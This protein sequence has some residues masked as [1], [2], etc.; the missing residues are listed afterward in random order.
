MSDQVSELYWFGPSYVYHMSEKDYLKAFHYDSATRTVAT[1]PALV[2]SVRPLDGMPGGFS[3]LSANGNTNGIVWTLF[4]NGDGQWNKVTGSFVAFDATSLAELWRDANPVSFAKFCAPTIADGKVFRPTFA[5]E[6]RFGVSGKVI[7][8]GLRP[9]GMGMRRDD[10]AA[11]AG[12][13]LT[14]DRPPAKSARLAMRPEAYIA[15]TGRSFMARVATESRSSRPPTPNN[16]PA[17]TRRPMP[18]RSLSPRSIGRRRRG[19]TWFAARSGS[20]GC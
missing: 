1:T 5:S 20:T 18:E 3:S 15:T 7:V 2:A 10:S 13:R 17:T 9:A 14:T 16:R 19:R 12:G 11:G 4:P 6:V 8:Y